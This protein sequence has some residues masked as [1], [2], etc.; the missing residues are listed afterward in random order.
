MA[1]KSSVMLA[2]L[3]IANPF[4]LL[5]YQ[6][7]SSAP[8]QTVNAPDHRGDKKPASLDNKPGHGPKEKL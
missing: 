2:L 4:V 1:K 7:C 8:K 6:N 5:F 3:F